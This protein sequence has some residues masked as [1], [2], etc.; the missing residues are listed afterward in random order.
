LNEYSLCDAYPLSDPSELIQRLGRARYISI[1]DARSDYHQAM[2]NPAYRWLTAFVCVEGLFELVCTPFGLKGDGYTFIRMLQA[3]LQPVNQYTTRFVDGMSIYS[4]DW[5]QHLIYI[6]RY[7]QTIKA[8][9]LTLNLRKSTLAQSNVRF[10]GHIVGS[11]TLRADPQKVSIVRVMKIP[12]TKRQVCQVSGFFSFFR[13]YIPRFAERVKPLTDLTSN[14]T[15]NVI[16]W[17][18]IH[19]QSFDSLNDALCKAAE[20]P[21]YNQ[22]KY[23]VQY[24][25]DASDVAVSGVSTQPAEDYEERPIAFASCK[26]NRTQQNWG[27]I[28]REAFA[29]NWPLQRFKQWA[30]GLKNY[31]TFRS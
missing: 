15:S 16:V 8:A 28:E 14:G 21:L 26:L 5:N 10:V 22:L 13:E 12:V 20:N 29:A 3:V 25:F 1:S 30:F 23:N 11:G 6:D 31:L 19:Q 2:V 9:G 17:L 27:T 7:L 24:F 18:P 4:N